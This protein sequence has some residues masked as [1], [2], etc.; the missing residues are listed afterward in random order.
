MY[1]IRLLLLEILNLRRGTL[2]NTLSN[3]YKALLLLLPETRFRGAAVTLIMG[4]DSCCLVVFASN[5]YWRVASTSR[6]LS[7]PPS[8]RQW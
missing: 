7:Q 1:Y 8:R 6:S 5:G 3:V 2:Y 4:G